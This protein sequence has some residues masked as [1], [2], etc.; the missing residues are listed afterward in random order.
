MAQNSGAPRVFGVAVTYERAAVLR[1]TLHEISRQTESV[2]SVVVVDNG[3]KNLADVVAREAGATYVRAGTNLGPAG[4]YALGVR[5]LFDAKIVDDRDWIM[6]ID[7]DDPP[8]TLDH[9]QKLLAFSH[10]LQSRMPVGCVGTV[11]ARLGAAGRMVR[12]DDSL[13]HGPVD[14]DSIG[15]GMTPL[16]SA[17][18]LRAVDFTFK[19]LFFG[20]EELAL[21]LAIKK[22]G[23]SVLADGDSWLNERR[24]WGRLGLHDRASIVEHEA[25]PWRRYYSARNLVLIVREHRAL[26]A[27]V[28]STASVI[29]GGA[30]ATWRTRRAA[31]LLSTLHGVAHAWLGIR[32]RTV[33]PGSKR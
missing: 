5:H 13:L 16:Y 11:G 7:D 9:V 26:T 4:G 17:A 8:N 23:F 10:S 31:P 30:L 15:N 3:S 12:L 24:R 25:P 2:Q 6:F 22:A 27:A 28:V 33:E 19:D 29:A 20:Y 21:G 1:A 14:V 18:A 32:G